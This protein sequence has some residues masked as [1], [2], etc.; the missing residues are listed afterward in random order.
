MIAAPTIERSGCSAGTG[1]PSRAW[2]RVT[3]AAA[4]LDR[5][6]G[7]GRLLKSIGR[8]TFIR[9][10]EPAIDVLIV[11][12]STDG[13]ARPL[14]DAFADRLRW[15]LIYHHEP[16]LGLVH[17]RNAQLTA[18]PADAHWLA[19]ID[20][21]EMPDP[22]WLDALLATAAATAAPL[23]AG[24]V[25]PVFAEAPPAWAVA[26]RFFEVGLPVDRTP[27]GHLYTGNALLS[28]PVV[29]AAGW[30]FDA[31]FNRSGGEDEHF[32]R[33]SLAA[34]LSAVFAAE[35]RVF[36]T[37]PPAKTTPRWVLRRHFRMGTT[38]ATIDRMNDPSFSMAARRSAKGLV[39]IAIGLARLLGAP[40]AGRRA[41]LPA[42]A[43]IARGVGAL[44]GILGIRFNEYSTGATNLDAPE[45]ALDRR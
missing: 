16:R 20:D 13:S 32:F 44:A 29:R 10:T 19:M 15:P 37:I 21:D 12:N 23:V 22:A 3:I 26:G 45:P 14:V 33:R 6:E 31:T 18:A 40:R 27:I 43:D 7:L 25:I 9:V 5:P 38:L 34:G 11:D 24:P 42:L 17:A 28:L 39:R 1:E 8:L 2:T 4:T 41:V 36:E 30:R 35:A